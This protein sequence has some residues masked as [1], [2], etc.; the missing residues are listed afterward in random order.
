MLCFG[1]GMSVEKQPLPYEV[2]E[3]NAEKTKHCHVPPTLQLTNQKE[4][5][6][7]FPTFYVPFYS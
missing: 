3:Q 5:C 2:I 7:C 1:A 6:F 4:S